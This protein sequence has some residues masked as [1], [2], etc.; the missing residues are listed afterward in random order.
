MSYTPLVPTINPP[1]VYPPQTSS[2]IPPSS[3][4]STVYTNQPV[5]QMSQVPQFFPGF[6]YTYVLDPMVELETATEALI[7]QKAQFEEQFLGCQFPNRYYVFVGSPNYYIGKKMLFKCKEKSE[8]CQRNCCP[9]GDREFSMVMK[10]VEPNK[11][12]DDTFTSPNITA[13]KPFKCTCFCL[14]RPEMS[15]FAGG[16]LVGTVKQPFYCCDPIFTIK[17]ASGKFKYFIHAD[18]CQCGFCCKNNICGKLSDVIFYIYSNLDKT[19]KIGSITKKVANLSEMITNAD[20][21]SIIFPKVAFP[22]DKLLLIAAGLMIDYQYFES[23]PE[24]SHD[25]GPHRQAI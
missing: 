7:H 3:P 18:C 9:A 10:Y 20:S 6:S 1:P 22:E 23:S 8:C 17:D 25:H 5:I 24:S 11:E 15:V 19:V 12:M 13:Y 14:E 2:S 4:I 16:K 21:Y